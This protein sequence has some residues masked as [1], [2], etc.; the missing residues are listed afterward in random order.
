MMI[1]N[2]RRVAM[3]GALTLGQAIAASAQGGAG[4]AYRAI[5]GGATTDP[6]MHQ[7]L[8]VTLSVAEAY[9]DNVI[10]GDLVG[11]FGVSPILQSGLYTNLAPAVAYAHSGRH[12]AFS[13]NAGSNL[14]YYS[15]AREFI[16]SSHFAGADLSAT[17]GRSVLS[18]G[19]TVSHSPSYFLGLLPSPAG[20]EAA[21]ADA[22][23]NAVHPESAYFSNSL[24]SLHYRLSGRSSVTALGSYRLI[25]FPSRS[26]ID[27]VRSY[28]VGGKYGY[29][30]SRNATLH[31]GYAYRDGRYSDAPNQPRI[32]IHDI[33]AGVD[34][35]RPLSLSRRTRIDFSLGSAV[36]SHPDPQRQAVE[37]QFRLLGSAALTRDMG[38]TWAARLHYNRGAGFA[39]G[40]NQPVFS[41]AVVA[42]VDGFFNRRVDFHSAAGVSYGEVGLNRGG[43]NKFRTYNGTLRVRAAISPGW[44]LFAEYLYYYYD[45]GAI[46]VTAS[47]VPLNLNRNSVR[48]GLTLWLPVVRR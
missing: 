21:A 47:E 31:F 46:V 37:R 7:S 3:V 10:G 12:T 29:D 6:S 26:A 14:R 42:S 23:E 19:Q 22:V 15:G 13:L 33:D 36:V 34:Y 32:V 17:F 39:G 27:D 25:D 1:A 2:V 40:F 41:D 18:I 20:L 38:R 45:L 9:D 43:A 4:R 24:F 16:G 44:A 35:H 48:L 30:L 5:F 28:S 8:D 11:G